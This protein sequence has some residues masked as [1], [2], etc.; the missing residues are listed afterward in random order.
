MA[1][2]R[3]TGELFG[4]EAPQPGEKGCLE[5]G[6]SFNKDGEIIDGDGNVYDGAYNL[7]RAAPSEGLK[8]AR[9]QH[10]DWSDADLHSLAKTYNSQLK[11][12]KTER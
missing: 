8:M 11:S 3:L 12:K 2:D 7:I 4:G 1:K 9:R 5:P 10:P 6:F